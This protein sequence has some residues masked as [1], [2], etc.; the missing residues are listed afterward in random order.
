MNDVASHEASADEVVFGL[1]RAATDIELFTSDNTCRVG[2]ILFIREYDSRLQCYTGTT[3]KRLVKAVQA[4]AAGQVVLS[5][6]VGD[7][8][9]TFF[10]SPELGQPLGRRGALR[11]QI[12]GA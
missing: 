10:V 9:D 11:L 8:A 5:L 6:G 4:S 12:P 2:D 7:A 1:L 3:A